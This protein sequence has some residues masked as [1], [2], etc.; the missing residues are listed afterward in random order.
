M[1]SVFRSLRRW[2]VVLAVAAST[3]VGLVTVATPA[4]AAVTAI[5]PHPAF[6]SSD[7]F[8]IWQSG[9]FLVYNNEWNTAVAGPQ[10]IWADSHQHW[11]VESTQSATTEVKTY[12]NVQLNYHS[13]PYTTIRSLRSTF[14]ESMPAVS[15]FDAEAAYDIWLNKFSVEVMV[16]VDNHGQTPSGHIIARIK[17]YGQEFAVWQGSQDQYSF[18][19]SGKQETSG[20]VH[21]FSAVRWLVNHGFLSS[22]DTLDQVGFGWE[23]ASTDGKPM[24]FTMTRYS[25]TTGL[26]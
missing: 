11:G 1:R 15:D 9:R 7:A 22:S 8:G 10:T 12:P 6:E 4:S 5:P 26:N 18:T 3:G 19:L 24:D 20:R 13:Q 21:L 14:T 25:L 16:W 23:I 2:P 17:I